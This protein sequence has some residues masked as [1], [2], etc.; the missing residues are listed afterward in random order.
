[1][2]WNVTEFKVLLRAAGVGGNTTRDGMR[3]VEVMRMGVSKGFGSV[4]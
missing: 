4:R 1:M 2:N 3:G